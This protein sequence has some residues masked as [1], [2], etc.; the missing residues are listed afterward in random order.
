MSLRAFVKVPVGQCLSLGS[1]FL[2]ASEIMPQRADLCQP[3]RHGSFIFTDS[4][5]RLL[6][7][8]D[9]K[10]TTRVIQDWCAKNA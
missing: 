8:I 1:D 5:N 10:F 2:H 3:D 9:L 4:S 6:A 7:S